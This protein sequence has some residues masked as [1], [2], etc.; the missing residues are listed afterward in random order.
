M[1]FKS[2]LCFLGWKL[3]EDDYPASIWT[4][5][6]DDGLDFQLHNSPKQNFLIIK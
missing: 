2:I 6:A 5:V 4:T 1:Y 3:L